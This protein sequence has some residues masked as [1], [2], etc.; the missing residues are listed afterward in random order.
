MAGYTTS[1]SGRSLSARTF[2]ECNGRAAEVLSRKGDGGNSRKV[3]MDDVLYVLSTLPQ[4]KNSRR[5]SVIPDGKDFVHSQSVGLTTQKGRAPTL[6]SLCSSCPLLAK[7][8]SRF[9]L[10]HD[11]GYRFTTITLNYNYASA[12]HHDVNH[13]DGHARII[14]LGNFEGGE[15]LLHESGNGESKK[16]DVRNRWFDFDGTVLHS[17]APFSGERY[18]LVYFRHQVWNTPRAGPIGKRLV[19]LGIPWPGELSTTSPPAGC[20]QCQPLSQTSEAVKGMYAVFP[21]SKVCP[22][23][24]SF[25]RPEFHS[26]LAMYGADVPNEKGAPIDVEPPSSGKPHFFRHDWGRSCETMQMVAARAVSFQVF[27]ELYRASSLALLRQAI[28]DGALPD[29]YEIEVMAEG[30]KISTRQRRK[31]S[32]ELNLPRSNIK[33]EHEAPTLVILY[34]LYDPAGTLTMAHLF[35]RVDP[36]LNPHAQ[37]ANKGRLRKKQNRKGGGADVAFRNTSAAT[38]LRP[39]LSA[40]ICNLAGVMKGSFLL[41]PFIGSGCLAKA[42]EAYGAFML[43]ADAL[44]VANIEGCAPERVV[45]NVYHHDQIYR[46]GPM[47]DAIVCDPPYGRREKHVD[48]FGNHD[49]HHETNDARA[50]AQFKILAPLFSLAS[51]RLEVNGRLVFGFFNYPKS[52]TCCWSIEDLPRHD[53]LSVLY[54]CR[55][56]WDYATGHSLARD[57]VVVQRT[58]K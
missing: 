35:S 24:A 51:E 32:M 55:E 21:N 48:Q 53:N 45:G 57:I 28:F 26:L 15:L 11:P 33:S 10:D 18:S 34:L 22:H 5:V 39:A 3:S 43:G 12:P 8:L 2:K 49:A 42:S 47:F 41:D 27:Q 58:C 56:Q 14:A 6:S 1:P 29:V 37:V 16:V 17:T 36:K 7:L 54:R 4:P 20:K 31:I 9:V 23:Y 19:E 50:L 38:P 46:T 40:L 30:K 25:V 52:P 13:E 44:K